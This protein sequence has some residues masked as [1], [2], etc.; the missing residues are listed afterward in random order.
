M[1]TAGRNSWLWAHIKVTPAALDRPLHLDG[2]LRGE[3]ER[4]LAQDVLAGLGR[5]DD[6]VGVQVVRQADVDGVEVCLG[7]HLPIVGVRRGAELGRR[8]AGPSRS[9]RRRPR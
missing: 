3:A 5:R 2:L 9:R 7:D 1:A 4:L 6:R 8:V